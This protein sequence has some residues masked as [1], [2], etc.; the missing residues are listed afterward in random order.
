MGMGRRVHRRIAEDIAE[1]I[2]DELQ[3]GAQAFRRRL[4]HT[5]VRVGEAPD[6]TVGAWPQP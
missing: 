3:P 4:E 5:F 1:D 6:G 2:I